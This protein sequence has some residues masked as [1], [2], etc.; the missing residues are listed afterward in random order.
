MDKKRKKMGGWERSK[1]NGAKKREREASKMKPL[2]SFFVLDTNSTKCIVPNVKSSN[3]VLHISSPE[4]GAGG[5]AALIAPDE[6]YAKQLQEPPAALNPD[7]IPMGLVADATQLVEAKPIIDLEDY[8]ITPVCHSGDRYDTGELRAIIDTREKYPSDPY[9]FRKTPVTPALI[10]A[11]LKVGPCQPGAMDDYDNFPPDATGRHFCAKWYVKQ[12]KY[13]TKTKRQWLVYS[14]R[15]NIMICF[16]CWLFSNWMGVWSNPNIGCKNFQKGKLRIEEHE[17]TE[18]HKTAQQKLLVTRYALL[19]DKTIISGLAMMERKHVEKNRKILSSI[20]DVILYLAKQGLAFRGHREFQGLGCPSVNEGNFLELIKLIAKNNTL[21]EQHLSKGDRNA[22]YLSPGIQN[23]LIQSLSNEILSLIKAEVMDAK[24]Y[25]IIADS[26]IDIARC[27]QFSLTL[28]YV[29]AQGDAVE[30]FIQFS[31]LPGGSAED[32]FNILQ[33]AIQKLGLSLSMCY[34]QSYDGTNTMSGELS[35]LQTRV[36]E[37]APNALYT[38]CC[39][40][41]L[42]LVLIDA[43][44]SNNQSKLFFGTLE[45]IYVFLTGSL[46]RLSILKEEQDKLEPFTKELKRLSDTRW[47]SRKQSVEA[48][49]LS[50]PAINLA[51]KRILNGEI[52]C[53]AKQLSDAQGLLEQINRYE[54]LILL[55]FWKKMLETAFYLSAYLQNS[56]IDMLTASHLIKVFENDMGKM[57]TEYESEFVKFE[58]EATKLAQKCDINTDYKQQRGRKTTIRFGEN[59]EDDVITDARKKFMVESYLVSLDAAKNRVNERFEHF[60][61]IASKFCVLDPDNFH[62]TDN[63]NKLALLADTYSDVIESQDVIVREFDSFKDMLTEIMNSNINENASVKLTI[64]TILKFMIANDMCCIYPNFSTLYKIYM[65]LPITSATAERSFSRLKNIKSYLRSTMG[66]DRLSNLALISIEREFA[67]EI[68][69]NKIVD[70]FAKMKSRRM[71]L[72]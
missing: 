1:M 11:I 66:E 49:L 18:S 22:T 55:F 69:C 13:D 56:S 10:R 53:T 54:F 9:L 20:I 59:A 6:E 36:R 24:F 2:E 12:T 71:D 15:A 25:A 19:N 43:V 46:P 14:P 5:K 68:D 4:E 63:V 61:N 17:E 16:V 40:H 51:L 58:N 60:H 32:F 29:T 35:G 48:V 67:T 21:L 33:T 27:D 45:S 57:R 41:N 39:A 44:S 50:L 42:N 65:T 38:H 52:K 26:T 28:R 64:N 31:E 62:K 47:A 3:D 70:H 8:A 30:R 37:V 72:L 34:G 7:D 23:E